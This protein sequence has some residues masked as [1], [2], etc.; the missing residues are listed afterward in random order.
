MCHKFCGIK[1]EI[2]HVQPKASSGPNTYSN[3]IPLCFDC[4][5]DMRTYDSAH[6]KGT[7]YSEKELIGHRD[8]WYAK[9][10]NTGGILELSTAATD[11]IVFSEL[12][13]VL[14]WNT[15][16]SF[17]SAK[18]ISG[19][20]I[21]IES[22]EKL[23]AFQ[24]L[25]E[26]PRFEFLDADLEGLKATLYQAITILIDAVGDHTT[27]S[28]KPGFIHVSPQMK[29][30]SYAKYQNVIKTIDDASAKV[31]ESYRELFRVAKRK[32]GEHAMPSTQ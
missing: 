28:E 27:P 13:K 6:P 1:I 22:F 24:I 30:K 17:M 19:V 31:L 25:C 11:R 21:E 20:P 16:L 7:K 14:P 15:G 12:T 3:A 32:L 29:I 5:A 8:A 10:K 9:I 26:E 23:S 18:K 4:H 2:H